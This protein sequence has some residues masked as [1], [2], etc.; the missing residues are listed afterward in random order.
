MLL[1]LPLGESSAKVRTGWPLDEEED[2]DLAIWA[3]VI[4]FTTRDGAA[5]GRSRPSASTSRRPTTSNG[6]GVPSPRPSAKW[7][8]EPCAASSGCLLRDP[9]LEP[10]AR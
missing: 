1:K 9:S 2:Y 8:A 5:P 3:G 4:P 7:R 10:P 6:T